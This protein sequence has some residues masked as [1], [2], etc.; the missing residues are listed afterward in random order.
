M[1]EEVREILPGLGLADGTFE[2]R[3]EPQPEVASHGGERVEFVVSLNP[4]FPPAPLARIASGGELARVMLAL[5]T[6]L[7]RLDRVPT[8]VFDEIDAGIGG[9]VAAAVAERLAQVA[10]E[11]Q[12]LV[13]THLPQVASRAAAHLRVQKGVTREGFAS[14]TVTSLEGE[15]RVEE[16]AR[17]LGGDPE[18]ARSREHAREMLLGAD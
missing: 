15:E 11:H 5:K 6:V 10:G 8:L 9:T 4:G 3:L 12:V 18:S 13:V 14:A 2:V 16:V 7:A 17:M 1:E